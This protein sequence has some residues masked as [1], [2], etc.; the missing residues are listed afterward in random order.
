MIPGFMSSMMMAARVP[1][2]VL[3]DRTSGTNIGNMTTGGG[4]AAAFDGNTSQ[5]SGVGARMAAASGSAAYVGKTL[6]TPRVFGSATVYGS[7]D[8]G[9]T[10]GGSL[11]ITLTMYGKNGAAPSSPTDGT[12]IGTLAGFTNTS[13][14]NDK[15]ISSSDLSTTWDHLW[16]NI[17]ASG[18]NTNL[19]AAELQLYAW[20]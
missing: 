4:L 6:A 8:N 16:I 12:I 9:Y 17:D 10:G 19:Y 7:N 11:T 2:L 15:T 13:G 5:A 3:I 18:A 14:T 1:E 20:E